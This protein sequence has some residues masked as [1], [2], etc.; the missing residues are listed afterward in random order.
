[1]VDGLAVGHPARH[2]AVL[3]P[4]GHLLA[5]GRGHGH[6]LI[7]LLVVLI[8]IVTIVVGVIVYLRRSRGERGES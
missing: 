5:A 7:I 1:M 2:L 4:A 8:V 3:Q 6:R